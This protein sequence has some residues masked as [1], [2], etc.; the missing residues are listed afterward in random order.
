VRRQ[1]SARV[2]TVEGAGHAV[3][4]DQTAALARLVDDFLFG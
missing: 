3:Q 1:P 2:E 4:S